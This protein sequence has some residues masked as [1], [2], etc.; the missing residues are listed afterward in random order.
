MT[1]LTVLPDDFAR[2]NLP[3]PLE[4]AILELGFE[5]TTPV[6]TNVLPHSLNGL[7]IIAQAQTGTGKTAAFLISII[8]YD[9]EN[10]VLD[11]RPPGTPFALII[12]PTRELVMQIANDAE[13]L[14]T[15]SDIKIVTLVGGLDYEKQIIADVECRALGFN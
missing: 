2:L 7:D 13:P 5:N 10:P 11:S 9:L 1:N 4:R 14:I 8:T 3:E 6:Q 15:Y 12:A